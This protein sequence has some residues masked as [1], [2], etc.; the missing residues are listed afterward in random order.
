VVACCRDRVVAVLALL[1]ATAGCADDEE[2]EEPRMDQPQTIAV[3]SPAFTDG[4]R[5]PVQ[6]TCDGDD[7]APP[8]AW[9]GVPGDSA[10]VALVLDDPDA[11]RGTFTH[12]IV[13][14]IPTDVASIDEAGVPRDGVEIENSGG[15][16]TYVG[17]CPPSGTHH[18]RFTV[19]A[20]S[21]PTGLDAGAGLDEALR[22]IEDRAVAWGRLTGTYSRDE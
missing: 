7:V 1:L 13:L 2:A 11:P 10:S 8:L 12:W 4:G 22:A 18:Y 6:Y 3:T 9:E 14:D 17:P 15:R 5:V 16:S 21:S 19:Y 20:L